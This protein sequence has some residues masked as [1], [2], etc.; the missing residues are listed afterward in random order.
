MNN[1]SPITQILAFVL[2]VLVQLVFFRD[3]WVFN[4]AYCWIYVTPLLL[5]PTY[6][7]DYILLF[8]AFILGLSVDVMYDKVGVNAAACVLL[9]YLR[10]MVLKMLAGQSTGNDEVK[11]FNLKNVGFQ[12]F[13]VYILILLF[14]HHLLLNL[15]NAA[16]SEFIWRA[17]VKTILSVVFT[18][19]IIVSTQMLYY[20]RRS[21]R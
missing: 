3:V 14:S 11:E 4:K 9:A 6:T 16:S 15:I 12:S 1:K 8:V 7:K 18:Y 10:P 21:S 20:T 5:L 19:V 2:Y 13:S 17:F